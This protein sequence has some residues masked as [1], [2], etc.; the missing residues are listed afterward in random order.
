MRAAI[1]VEGL[2]KIY[3]LPL[4]R[5]VRRWLRSG[6]ANEPLWSL[7]DLHFEVQQGESLGIIGYNGAGKST[8]LKIL[9]GVTPPTRGDVTVKGAIFPMIELN[10]GMN[11]DLT[12]RE[13]V[14]LLGAIMGIPSRDLT[15]KLPVIEEFC[16]LGAWF[17]RPVWQYSSGMMARLGFAVALNA[18]ADILLIDEVLAVGDIT[19]Q[20]KS[21]DRMEQMQQDGKTVIFVSHS[22]RQV[23]RLCSR[24][25]LLDKG[26]QV[27]LGPTH[28]VISQYYDTA[29]TKILEH[30]SEDHQ[31]R[32]VILQHKEPNLPIEL[33]EMELFDHDNLK[34]N[35]LLTHD[36]L[37]I[38]LTYTSREKI[39]KAMIGIGILTVDSVYLASLEYDLPHPIEIGSGTFECT[40]PQ[41]P[42]LS[43]IYVLQCK[44][45]NSGGGIVGGGRGLAMFSVATPEEIAGHNRYGVIHVSAEWK[46]YHAS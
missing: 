41:L 7:Q 23:E 32:E 38:Q 37:K 46:H 34:I 24:V 44:I 35:R 4:G 30:Y 9:A 17:D 11:N 45:I 25:L 18:E 2:W 28:E 21:L 33:H 14:H 10:A 27:A 3:G 22:I 20:R 5:Q 42:F 1:Q 19:F 39:N 31:S 15:A 8:L 12:G 26:R 40:I 29:N 36:S 16:E 43:G 13:N 6:P